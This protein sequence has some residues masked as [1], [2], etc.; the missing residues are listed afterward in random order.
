VPRA[1]TPVLPPWTRAH[2]VGIDE[3]GMGPR[4]GPLIVTAVLATVDDAGAKLVSSRPRGAVAKRIG[5]SKKLVTFDDSAL[6]APAEID[7]MRG[8]GR[9][10]RRLAVEADR[11]EK[12]ARRARALAARAAAG[13]DG[14]GPRFTE[15]AVVEGDELLRVADAL[16]DGATRS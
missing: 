16:R 11:G 15:G 2:Y 7:V 13:S 12:L 4:L 14:P 10:Q 8:A 6:G 9:L 5:D 1:I 3:N